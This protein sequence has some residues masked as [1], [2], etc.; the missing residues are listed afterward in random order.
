MINLFIPVLVG[1]AGSRLFY[2]PMHGEG[3]PEMGRYSAGYLMCVWCMRMIGMSDEWTVKALLIGGAVGL[4]VA[5]AR[6]TR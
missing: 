4:G 6:V 5:L 1:Y 2:E 3:F